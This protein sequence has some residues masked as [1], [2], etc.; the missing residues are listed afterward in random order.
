MTEL[1]INWLLRAA[2]QLTSC[3]FDQ[4]IRLKVVCQFPSTKA[5]KSIVMRYA[6]ED[7]GT[8]LPSSVIVKPVSPGDP[9][10]RIGFLNDLASCKFLDQLSLPQ[11]LGPKLFCADSERQILIIEDLGDGEGASLE[12]VLETGSCRRAEEALSEYARAIGRIHAQTAGN[13]DSYYEIRDGLES[14][15]PR[16]DL[17][18]H[19]WS[20]PLCLPSKGRYVAR[21][22]GRYRRVSKRVCVNPSGAIEGEIARVIHRVEES[23]RPFLAF[24]QGDQNGVGGFIRKEGRLRAFDF[25]CGWFRHALREGIPA[26]ITWGCMKRVPRTVAD[27]IERIYREELAKGC[28]GAMD[29]TT[30]IRAKVEASAHWHVFHVNVRLSKALLEDHR[31]GPS[32][33]RQQVV[34]WLTAFAEISEESAD[35]FA[36]GECARQIVNQLGSFWSHE[37]FELPVYRAFL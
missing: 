11:P 20:D 36:L 33:V 18:T 13:A 7:R 6:L 12:D 15:R 24:A 17:L 28:S 16:Y 2:E 31:R 14:A 10:R 8:G 26:R 9:C 25:D 27:E 19:P 1:G 5:K 3:H 37:C 29:D 23:P 35:L 34:A 30:F 4:R 32:T 22:I 21:A